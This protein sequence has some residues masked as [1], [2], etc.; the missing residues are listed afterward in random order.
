MISMP[1]MYFREVVRDKKASALRKQH[2]LRLHFYIEAKS[3]IY[4]DSNT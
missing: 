3:N 1:Y 2:V 4:S